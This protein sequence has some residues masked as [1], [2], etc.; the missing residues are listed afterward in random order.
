MSSRNTWRWVACC[1][2]RLQRNSASTYLSSTVAQNT[3]QHHDCQ[4]SIEGLDRFA[5][6]FEGRGTGLKLTAASSVIHIDRWWNP[7]VEDQATDRAW[8]IGQTAT[9][10]VHK[11]ATRATIEERID[12]L[13]AE[14]R[15][16]ADRVLGGGNAW[17]TEMSGDELRELLELTCERSP[18]SA[19]MGRQGRDP[20]LLPST[21]AGT[22]D[23]DYRSEERVAPLRMLRCRIRCR[24]RWPDRRHRH[25][26]SRN[27]SHQNDRRTSDR[28]RESLT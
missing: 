22:S 26:G 21:P 19:N 4:V 16:L 10:L 6:E 28:R 3:A 20:G 2:V 17:V 27:A 8:R 25:G 7:A 5:G 9:V 13:L 15:T 11:L 14:K 12:T 1:N 18:P 23:T 24:I